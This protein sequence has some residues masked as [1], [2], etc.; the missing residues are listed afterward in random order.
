M[1]EVTAPTNARRRLPS[2]IRIRMP[3]APTFNQTD[4]LIDGLRLHTVCESAKCPNRSE[5]W[6]KGTAT[7][8]IGGNHCTRACKFC[9]V[10]TAK[11]LPLDADEPR[12]VA[13]AIQRMG[14][15]HAV[16]T[17]VARDDVPDGGA[18]HFRRTVEEV[19]RLCGTI[20]IEVLTPDFDGRRECVETVLSARPDVFN[21]NV[22][23]VLRLTPSVRFRFTYERSLSVLR[24]AKEISPE[25]YTKSGIMLGL[26][27]TQDEVLRTMADAR[28]VGCDIF[29][30][31]QYL[32]PTRANLPVAEFVAPEQFARYKTQALKMGFLHVASA[33]LVRSSYHADDFVPRSRA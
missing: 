27:E 4:H 10:P 6:S 20:S 30:M 11:P 23:T 7:V 19:R 28:A 24:M 25:T 32:Q 3:T 1:S 18:E 9:S 16:I 33:P 22:E 12:R 26:G 21:H 31:G 13:E 29:T 17:A 15:K 5:C 14:L 2:W 8:M